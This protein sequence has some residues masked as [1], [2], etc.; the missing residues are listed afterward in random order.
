MKTH[1]YGDSNAFMILASQR[2]GLN[3]AHIEDAKKQLEGGSIHPMVSAAM[4]KEAS[5]MNDQLRHDAALIAKAN[6][7]V[8]HIA[9]EYGFGT[10]LTKDAFLAL[11]AEAESI[12]MDQAQ[13]RELPEHQPRM[14]MIERLMAAASWT[15][16]PDH[17]C[18]QT[19]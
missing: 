15:L 18:I 9:M 14:Q 19:C 11:Q 7:H 10:D 16:H 6:I 2:M 13:G 4:G 3:P 8:E 12:G 1:T 17:G 5:A